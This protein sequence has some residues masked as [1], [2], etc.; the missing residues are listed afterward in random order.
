M[1]AIPSGCESIAIATGWLSELMALLATYKPEVQPLSLM[2]Q[3]DRQ[4]V[5]PIWPF[6]VI[7]PLSVHF[8]GFRHPG[9]KLIPLKPTF[10]RDVTSLSPFKLTF[11]MICP[12]GEPLTRHFRG[13]VTSC[14]PFKPTFSWVAASFTTFKLTFRGLQPHLHPL[15]WPLRGL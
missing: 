14:T 13:V 12:L 15:S 8:R 2:G 9:R 6:L 3:L 11:S 1:E 4:G 7:L 10:T 5:G